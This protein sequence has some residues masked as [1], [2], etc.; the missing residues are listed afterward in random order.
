M[1]GAGRSVLTV[2]RE[3]LARQLDSVM[4]QQYDSLM[5]LYLEGGELQEVPPALRLLFIPVNRRLLQTSVAYDAAEG[6]AQV[7]ISVLIV[8]GETDL[9]VSVRDAEALSAARPGSEL[10]V[11]PEA[12]HVFK[13]TAS[14]DLGGQIVS[15]TGPSLPIVPELV[16][17]IVEWMSQLP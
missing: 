5:A 12:N 17:A 15:Y 6:M 4:L 11:I 9:Q 8:Q 13:H 1:A 16:D 2:L 7:R 14:R 3:Q 10:V